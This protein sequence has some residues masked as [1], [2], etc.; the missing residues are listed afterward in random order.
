MCFSS[1]FQE[2]LRLLV[3]GPH[4]E[5]SCCRTSCL[6]YLGS[7]TQMLHSGNHNDFNRTHRQNVS[8]SVG[9]EGF[10]SH[11][12]NAHALMGRWVP[13]LLRVLHLSCLQD[14]DH[15]VCSLRFPTTPFLL[16]FSPHQMCFYANISRKRITQTIC[17]LGR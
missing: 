4:S 10:F 5:D 3:Q 6:N 12:E 14:G 16:S 8:S 11:L 15:L 1:K 9:L 13:L 2:M 7:E 17:S